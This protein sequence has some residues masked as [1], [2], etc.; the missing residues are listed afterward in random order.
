MAQIR[1]KSEAIEKARTQQKVQLEQ[2]IKQRQDL[3]IQQK[4]K[5][6]VASHRMIEGRNRQNEIN[7]AREKAHAKQKADFDQKMLQLQAQ[8]KQQRETFAAAS[9]RM[10]EDRNLQ[11]E[12]TQ[13]HEKAHAQQR[14][15]FQE[16]MTKK[17]A[18]AKQKREQTAVASRK[19]L[20]YQKRQHELEEIRVKAQ[21]QETQRR[22][23]AQQKEII[24][25]QKK[26]QVQSQ[27]TDRAHQERLEYI[28]T[29]GRKK[30]IE[31]ETQQEVKQQ[32]FL[33]NG[34]VRQIEQGPPAT[35]LRRVDTTATGVVTSIPKTK[36]DIDLPSEKRKQE[37][38]EGIR[39]RLG[40]RTLNANVFKGRKMLWPR[41]PELVVQIHAPQH[42]QLLLRVLSLLL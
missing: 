2:T 42:Q 24:Q 29:K 37:K 10:I 40:S 38:L 26:R 1:Q 17:I 9:R 7:E 21:V 35:A 15:Q 18:L 20:E 6:A 41:W 19:S 32:K 4:R 39:R 13:A 30:E 25:E 33:E 5:A 8:A 28:R 22:I 31:W 16:K 3:A 11:Q 14:A 23:E 27:I 34:K 36:T 12:M